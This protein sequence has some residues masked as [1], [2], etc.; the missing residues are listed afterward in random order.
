[1]RQR[2]PDFSALTTVQRSC[3]T[4]EVQA[5]VMQGVYWRLPLLQNSA[6]TLV[7]P[8]HCTRLHKYCTS[9]RVHTTTSKLR[10]RIV[11][12]PRPLRNHRQIA[13]KTCR[14]SQGLRRNHKGF[15]G[16]QSPSVIHCMASSRREQ[17]RNKVFTVYRCLVEIRQA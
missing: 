2:A 14:D 5:S 15:R 10:L 7:I 4:T 16:Q 12:L 8:R 6:R 1:M 11:L 13:Q 3:S 17:T 9:V